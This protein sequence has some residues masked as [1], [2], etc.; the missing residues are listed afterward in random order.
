MKS[1]HVGRH[2]KGWYID[3][4]SNN[5]VTGKFTAT[6]YGVEMCAGTQEALIKMIDVKYYEQRKNS[7]V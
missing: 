5:P 2:Y 4:R 1:N 6:Q 3:Y 7:L